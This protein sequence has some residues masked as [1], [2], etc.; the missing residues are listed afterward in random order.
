MR[1]EDHKPKGS[2]DNFVLEDVDRMGL[3]VLASQDPGAGQLYS[4]TGHGCTHLS[5]YKTTHLNKVGL[6]CFVVFCFVDRVSTC[7][8]E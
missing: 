6:L 7:D 2:L 4:F 1:Q 5:I 3:G 8:K